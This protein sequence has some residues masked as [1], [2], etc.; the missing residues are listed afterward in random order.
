MLAHVSRLRPSHWFIPASGALLAAAALSCGLVLALTGRFGQAM[1]PL[2]TPAGTPARSDVLHVVALGDSITEGTGDDRGGYA[3][4]VVAALR[5]GDK[6]KSQEIVFANLAVAGLET[7]E[8]LASIAAPE[9]RRQLQAADLILISA[10]GNDLSHGLRAQPG[11]DEPA[12][13]SS[14]IPTD[15]ASAAP[16]FAP[17]ATRRQ[18]RRNLE[19][20]LTELHTLCPRANVRLLG[21][22]NPF[23]VL[24]A[25]LPAGR[26]QLRLWNDAIDQA[27]E[28]HANVVVVPIAD[29]IA[30]RPDLL[31]GDRYHPGPKGHELI[32]ERVLSTLPDAPP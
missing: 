19:Q 30:A 12:P 11:R 13:A 32:A 23:D 20:L 27:A 31:A 4:R 10:A 24:P 21:L 7:G 28:A 14:E 15:G 16:L 29:L 26:A 8:V 3:A 5:R 25:D 2:P 22:Y 9:A 1:A 18:A 6:G 17:E